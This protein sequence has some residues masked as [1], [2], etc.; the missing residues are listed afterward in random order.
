MTKMDSQ[1]LGRDKL[2]S[3]LL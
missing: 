2:P 3:F 1:R